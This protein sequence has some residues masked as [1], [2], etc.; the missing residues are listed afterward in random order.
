[1]HVV[2]TLVIF[3]HMERGRIVKKQRETNM[4]KKVVKDSPV[5]KPLKVGCLTSG[6]NY[7]VVHRSDDNEIKVGE[8]LALEVGSTNWSKYTLYGPPREPVALNHVRYF[9]YNSELLAA[10]KGAIVTPNRGWARDRI[11]KLRNEI[12]QLEMDYDLPLD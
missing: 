7:I 6:I 1:M 5:T 12:I 10:I 8:R 11:D 2:S 3:P 4:A 9:K